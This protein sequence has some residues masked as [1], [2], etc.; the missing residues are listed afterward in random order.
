MLCGSLTCAVF[1]TVAALDA[2][3]WPNPREIVLDF[4]T[5]ERE[6]GKSYI[7]R[8]HLAIYGGCKKHSRSLALSV[9][10]FFLIPSLYLSL[11]A[12]DSPQGLVELKD[13]ADYH[14]LK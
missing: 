3:S 6:G 4:S 10:P 8:Q 7:H 5:K 9:P 2:L 12:L 1:H 11:L 14:P 13:T